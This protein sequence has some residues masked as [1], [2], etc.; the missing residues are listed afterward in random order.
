M[1]ILQ[2]VEQ[3]LIGL[4]DPVTDYLP[5]FSMADEASGHYHPPIACPHDRVC[6]ISRMTRLSSSRQR[7]P[8]YDEAALEEYVRELSESELL[9]A[10]ARIIRT[11]ALALMCWVM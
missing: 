11:A 8:R 3:G 1:A 5:Y 2:L 4:D 9:F 6:P 7:K 10:P